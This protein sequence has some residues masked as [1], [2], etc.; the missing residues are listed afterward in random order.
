MK[1]AHEL[2]FPPFRLDLDEDRLWRGDDEISLKPKAR[3]MLRYLATHPRR[4]VSKSELIEAVWEGGHVSATTVR[5]T[6]RELRHALAPGQDGREIIETAHGRGYRFMGDLDRREAPELRPPPRP[7]KPL[8]GRDDALGQLSRWLEDASQGHRHVGFVVGEAGIGKTTLIEAFR[9]GLEED[10]LLCGY[11]QCIGGHGD[12]DPYRPLLEALERLC[13]GPGGH[14]VIDRLRRYAPTWLLEIPG[15]LDAA[16]ARRLAHASI[17]VNQDRMLQE[18]AGAMDAISQDEPAV[19]ILEDLHWA[20]GATLS[21]IE[22]LARRTE[23]ARLLVLGTHR[24]VPSAEQSG[25][26][27]RLGTMRVELDVHGLSDEVALPRL[28][29]EAVRDYLTERFPGVE[30]SEELAEKISRPKRGE[31]PW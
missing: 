16:E 13:R 2:V 20:D 21:A 3:T 26:P 10:G 19:V 30:G 27:A 28:A 4:L 14:R 1:D 25:P 23:P 7:R 12:R 22:L 17:R 24:P 8:F 6:L 29:G 18:L 9:H 11:G 15:L 31:P 5:S